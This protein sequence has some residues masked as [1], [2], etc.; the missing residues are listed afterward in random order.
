M[1][2]FLVL[3]YIIIITETVSCN[4]KRCGGLAEYDTKSESTCCTPHKIKILIQMPKQAQLPAV[5]WQNKPALIPLIKDQ[6][7]EM[8]EIEPNVKIP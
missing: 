1:T 3:Y 7:W 6:T 2:I 5:V 8:A 4:T